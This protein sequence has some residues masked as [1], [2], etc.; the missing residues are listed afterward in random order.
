MG[1]LCVGLKEGGQRSWARCITWPEG[2][3]GFTMFLFYF[4]RAPCNTQQIRLTVDNFLCTSV[5]ARRRPAPSPA[6]VSTV[7]PM[8][9]CCLISLT[10]AVAV[11]ADSP[12]RGDSAPAGGAPRRDSRAS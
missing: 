10:E 4:K 6:A 1:A 3:H 5:L 7:C 9:P 12:Q 8:S 2:G 11:A